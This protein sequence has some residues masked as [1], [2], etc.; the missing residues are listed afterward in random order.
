M[1]KLYFLLMLL[2]ALLPWAAN[3]QT[4]KTV[5]D[6]NTTTNSCV[7]F[8]GNWADN[9]LQCEM[10]YPASVLEDMDGGTISALKFYTNGTSTISTESGSNN[11]DGTFTIF[12][13][14]VESTTLSAF[15]GTTGATTVLEAQIG[16]VNGEMTIEF[17]TP[18]TYNGGNLLIGVY[19]ATG[20]H[21]KSQY[22]IGNT[23]SGASIYGRSG[24]SY[25][26][27]QANF[28]PKTTFTY[29]PAATGDTPKPTGFAVNNILHNQ[30]DLS[31]TENG[32]ATSWQICVNGDEE[33]LISANTNPYTLT[34]LTPLTAYTVKVRS[35]GTPNSDW[36]TSKNFSTT[37]QAE[38]VGDSWS[39]D[40][41]GASCGWELI[42]GT[43]TNQ[44]VWGTAT[45]NGGTHALYISNDGG[46]TY[47][48]T[49]SGAERV[50]AQKLLNFETGKY[51][52]SFDWECNGESSN[53]DYLSVGLL[54]ASA[55]ITADNTN[56][57]TLPTGW[58]AV[59]NQQYLL[60]QT[61]WQTAPEKAIQLTAGNYYLVL[62]WRQDGNG[63]SSG[64]IMPAAVDNV[65]IT[66][67]ACP[68]D[69][70][71]LAVAD[72]PA[73]TQTTATVTWTAGEAT[74]WQVATKTG[75]GDWTILPTIYNTNSA[76]LTGLTAATTYQVKA[77]AYCN[78][79][80][81]GTW[82]EPITLT[83]AC[84][85]N[86]PLDYTC[87][88][89][90]PNTTGSYQL[91][92]CWTRM[93]SSPSYPN[94][95]TSNY[96]GG[97]H[98][99]YFYVYS[100]TSYRNE[101]AALP[102]I[103]AELNTIRV[104]FYGKVSSSTA[105]ND[106]NIGYVTDLGNVETFTLVETVT[107]TTNYDKYTV[108]FRN[109]S[110]NNGYIAIQ[111]KYTSSTKYTYIDD[112]TVEAIPSCL[113]P[114]VA[115]VVENS[116]TVNSVQLTWT[117]G[118]E[119]PET[120]W[121]VQYKKATDE[122]YTT[123]NVTI[124]D[125][126]DGKY[127]LSGLDASTSY[128][129]QVA[130][131][132]DPSNAEA[133]SEYTAGPDF[134]TACAAVTVDAEHHYT[135]N[136]NSYT[137]G[138]TS[139]S[140]PSNY[141]ND[142]LPTCWQ[143]LNR[144]ENS[145]TYPQAFL[146]SSTSYAVSGN[147]LFFKSS[148][149]TPLYAI[150]PEFTNNI[151]DLMLTFTYRNE[152]TSAN[153]GTLVAGY[154][155]DPTNAATFDTV[156]ICDRTQ[157][158]TEKEVFFENVPAGSYIV[159]KYQGGSNDNYYLSIDNVTVEPAPTCRK[160]SGLTKDAT[161]AHTA[162]LHWTNGSDDQTAWQIAYSTDANF[163]PDTVAAP[164]NVTTNPTTIEGLA[165]STT[166]YAYVR[167]YCGGTDYSAWCKT[168]VSFTTL[169]G[170]A[171]PTGLAVANA[172]ITSSKATATWKAV[173]S[174]ILH[175]YYQL[176]L[177][178]ESAAP[179]NETDPTFTNITD[180][181]KLFTSLTPNT[182]YKVYVRDFCGTDGYSNWSSAVTFTTKVGNAAPTNFEHDPLTLTSNEV[183]VNW[184]GV[185]TNDNH[186]SYELYISTQSTRPEPLNED[187]LMTNITGTSYHYTGLNS[188]TTYYVWV[189][190]NCG[191]DGNSEWT[192]LTGNSFT[193]A[194]SCQAPDGLVANDITAHTAIIIWN[195]YGQSAFNL[196]YSTDETNWT[197]VDEPGVTYEMVNLDGETTYYVQVQADCHSE[198]WS[199]S[200]DFTT[201][202]AC[203]IPTGLAATLTPGDGTV[204]N[205]SWT[206]E[207][208]NWVVAYKKD[209]DADFTEVEAN[210]NPF[211]LTNLTAETAYTVK[212]KA[213][214]G[215]VDGES[216]WSNTISF[217][218]TNAY[219]VNNGTSKSDGNVPL[220]GNYK[221]SY[222]QMIYTAAQLA[223]AG[224][225][226]PCSIT[227][228]GFNSKADNTIMRLPT[229]YMGTTAKS[230]FS[231]TTDFISI[232]NLSEVYSRE[233]SD[234]T[235]DPDL[236]SITAGWNEFV[237][238]EPFEY[239][240]TSNLVIAMHC[241]I[242]SNFSSSSFYYVATI[243]NQ[244]V[245]T[246]SDADNPDPNTYEGNWDS[247]S[248]SK[249]NTKNLP[250]LRLFANP[251]SC[252]KPTALTASNE[253]TTSVDLSWTAT[254]GTTTWQICVNGDE[255]HLT[256][257]TT[258]PYTL[259]GLIPGTDYS[260]KVRAHC[261]ENDFSAWSSAENFTTVATCTEPSALTVVENSVEAHQAQINWTAGGEE[262]QWDIYYSTGNTAPTSGTT[263]TV[264]KTS[265]KPYTITGLTANQT[266]YYVW[267]RA[268]CGDEEGQQSSWIGGVDF[269]TECEA[270]TSFPWREDFEN[271]S[272]GDFSAPCWVNERIQD[273][274]GNSGS[275]F[276]F[277][278][279][280][281]TNGTNS[282]HQLQLPDMKAGTITKLR[283]PEMTLAGGTDYQFVFD[284]YRDNNSKANEGIKIYASTNGEIEGATELGYIQ[285][286]KD[287]IPVE[288]SIGWYT[289]EF[290]IPFTGTCYI[291]LLGQS[292][293]G[294]ASYMDNFV[295]EQI[296]TCLRP[297]AIAKDATTAHT[298]TLSWTN[299]EEG[300]DAWQIAYSTDANFN[301]DTVAAPADVT[302]NPGTIEGLAASTTYYAYVRANCGNGDYSAWSKTKA[303][304]ATIAGN[305]VPTGLAYDAN[306]LTSSEVTVSW[307]GVATND[308]HAS[309]E[310]YISTQSTR[311]EPLFDDSLITGIIDP[312]RQLSDLAPETKYYVWVR[313]NCGAD[314]YSNWSSSINF[315][316]KSNCPAP[317]GLTASEV[318]DSTA[319]LRWTTNGLSAFN[320]R[321]K[322][323]DANDWTVKNNVNSLDT[324][325]QLTANTAYQVQ[326]QAACNTE[327]WSAT[328]NF[329][330]ECAAITIT[331]NNPYT[332]DFESPVVTAVYNTNTEADLKVPYCWGESYAKTTSGSTP[333]ARQ[334]PHLIKADAGTSGYNYSNPASQV[335]YFYGYGYGYAML[336]EFTNPLNELQISFKWA[337]ENQTNG[338]LYLGYITAN[339]ENYN[340][341]K[342]IKSFQAN[343]G[344]YHN[345]RTDS[346][347]LYNVPDSA[348][349]LAFYWYAYNQYGANIDDIEI[350]LAPT[351]PPLLAMSAV[352]SDTVLH[353][354]GAVWMPVV[355]VEP[356]NYDMRYGIVN[357]PEQYI[358]GA[359]IDS[360]ICVIN[361]LYSDSLYYIH[362][363][364][365][366][367][368]NDYSEWMTKS[369]R[370][371]VGSCATITNLHVDLTGDG[372]NSATIS[373][374]S[375]ESAT[376]DLYDIHVSTTPVTDLSTL[377][378]GNC[379]FP[380]A[381]RDTTFSLPN[382][383]YSG[384][385]LTPNTTYY[386][387]VR[388]RCNYNDGNSDWAET[389]FTTLSAC[390]VPVNASVSLTSKMLAT[391]TWERGDVNQAD[392]YMLIAAD[393]EMSAQE[394]ET[395]QAHVSNIQ[396]THYSFSGNYTQ[397]YYIYVA[398]NCGNEGN[399]PYVYAGSVT[400]P[401]AC[402]PVQNVTASNI[403]PNTVQLSWNRG[404]WGEETQ[405]N[406]VRYKNGVQENE[407]VVSDTVVTIFGLDAATNYEF[408]V[409]AKCDDGF[410]IL[411]P[412][413]NVTTAATPDACYTV[414][415]S[416]TT[417]NS[418]TP[419]FGY[420]CDAVQKTQSIYPASM[421]TELQGKTFTGLKY[422]VESGGS[423]SSNR[424]WETKNF[425]VKMANV[426]EENLSAGF[427][428]PDNYTTVYTGTL[429]A[430]TATGME[431]SF[432]GTA[433]FTYTGGN[434]LVE[435][436]LPV[437]DSWSSCTFYGVSQ[438]NGSRTVYGTNTS[439][440]QNF[441]PKV[442]L[443]IPD[444][445][446]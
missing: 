141:P 171:T 255:E 367:G 137:S 281:S 153:D 390:R 211:G 81:Q 185:A 38:V 327:V 364:A 86:Y 41:E 142:K 346:V 48:Y 273:G 155:T 193:T 127:T 75:D 351:C 252:P 332:E 262:T 199:A 396:E 64:T 152:G 10:V 54:P 446:S 328:T 403:T 245:Y 438:N 23:V 205:L 228:I 135:E 282:T 143:F 72:D 170:N 358:G 46:T 382:N 91:P 258:N 360:Q 164:V 385:A 11:W 187:S 272:A 169:A 190:D 269:T 291:I 313:D 203:H 401:A 434:L 412:A 261:G 100:G 210:T 223:D 25:S 95:S 2:A 237:L 406:V 405:W 347:Y 320:L 17:T 296:P 285:H 301:P 126:T 105:D 407:R 204:A 251:V 253:E 154:M 425:I 416:T 88:F 139:T 76:A 443:R 423:N 159:F 410:S 214:C 321:Y 14:E 84:L 244:V 62:R 21:Y 215:G 331:E 60:G 413:V 345:L 178:T 217:T 362:V 121:K 316:T 218:P 184:N 278:I 53:F 304:F 208:S 239:D 201:L 202:V 378:N 417:T 257:A 80:D 235:D 398:N 225:T 220:V 90:G 118:N 394:L 260:V 399:S 421:L 4:T 133:V 63:P 344:S 319:V 5:Y 59:H 355:G 31:W 35:V 77:R 40:F 163:N 3:A 326:V 94:V 338:I 286:Y 279:Y 234:N 24:E 212:V 393:H 375:S 207:A 93:G 191:T 299:G 173:A 444:A 435:F 309:Y 197:T 241:G 336:P 109:V 49:V 103:D 29:E 445:G 73:V 150:L 274:T 439:T 315:T 157:T 395:A 20:G 335:L 400:F 329:R 123:V 194:A 34:G 125:L 104:S 166:Y 66:R 297:L 230:S 182:Q 156:L 370:T 307:T 115:N 283:L 51:T 124:G 270:V 122:N 67:V 259:D 429:S 149:S 420:N 340:S 134:T 238:D 68:Y 374:N 33:N 294:T 110:D 117:S 177:S 361:N 113:E 312:M 19:Y 167:A 99:L 186:A 418:T 119:T 339:D 389:T 50:Y 85:E 96:H 386:V 414:A 116:E 92:L 300:Q 381:T 97:T 322:A 240:G 18:Y 387:Y 140:V 28:L 175:E 342:T 206:S 47:T 325:T 275:L 310:L 436:E 83:T 334:K 195:T 144:R 384:F 130:A 161:T 392:N 213:V 174:N 148:S 232:N 419:V 271:Y 427:V 162:T 422:Y 52:F 243:N 131:W 57:G 107:L 138:S 13:K 428:T 391:V 70:A 324:L 353:T 379:E 432:N 6:Q 120:N 348:T 356:N 411:S 383:T 145:S 102:A 200:M 216:K 222:D 45:N 32:T 209:G 368:G 404:E 7:P 198:E 180:T 314:G 249:Y 287:S 69:V 371:P 311:P 288:A 219:Y 341:F 397:T 151:S 373:W 415:N 289:Y 442:D 333:S 409:Q 233:Y 227:K 189:R 306:T 78:A 268:H 192:A 61:T 250:S 82:C 176:Y 39:D 276:I 357:D 55:T 108:S 146:S 56:S 183:T 295:V 317:D 236:W 366:C 98:S 284:M 8:W 229:L 318:T 231:S 372:T 172:N 265:T 350:S 343:S 293:W 247:Y 365:N 280:T 87:G 22:F 441:L 168:K 16:L 128:N 330:T 42:N 58:I 132:C 79:N 256:N 263:P 160:P 89:E 26:V 136:F 369:V 129:W 292:Q 221:S 1:K 37:A 349:R 254:G 352:A 181:C 298:A 264:S 147:C 114:T 111:S 426:N 196:R 277:K 376:S 337:T 65:S 44:W 431:I 402:P 437:K 408:K 440:V 242:A 359:T 9:S 267:V 305:K 380:Q 71:G 226:G 302:N 12:M 158:K 30:A 430:S 188:E 15:T 363:R 27:N 303:T 433:A 248:G 266:T 112:I 106:I 179:T 43:L 388:T 323:E 308:N 36:S 354:I 290:P 74:Q 246:R 224:I 424:S 165:Q 101:I 377:E